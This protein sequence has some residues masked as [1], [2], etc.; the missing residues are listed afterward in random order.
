M[1]VYIIVGERQEVGQEE[2]G[3]P[4]VTSNYDEIVRVFDSE[5]KA[6]VFIES[7]RL[8]KPKKK[9]F[10]GIEYYKT[11]HYSLEIVQCSVD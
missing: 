2:I 3:G 11:G 1:I 6:T 5:E 7:N 4:F 10:S 9:S 8:K